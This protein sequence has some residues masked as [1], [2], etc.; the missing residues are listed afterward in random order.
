MLSIFEVLDSIGLSRSLLT[1][2]NQ[3]LF[4]DESEKHKLVKDV[5]K[6]A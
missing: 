5:W 6:G 2:C 4:D 1:V 3:K